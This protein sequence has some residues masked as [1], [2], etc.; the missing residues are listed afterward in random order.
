VG[1]HVEP[2]R[3][4]LVNH[5]AFIDAATGR[6]IR[7]GVGSDGSYV[8]AALSDGTVRG[9]DVSTGKERPI[10]QPNLENIPSIGPGGGSDLQRVVFSRD[11]RSAAFIGE[12]WVQIVDMAG[13]DRRFKAPKALFPIRACE[14]SPDGA[15]LVMVREA[16]AKKFRVGHYSGSSAPTSTVVWLD[17]KTGSVRREIEL[18]ESFVRSL[19]FSPDGQAIAAGTLLTHPARGIIRIFRLQDKNEIQTIESPCPWIEALCYSP[20]GRRIVAGMSDTSIVIWDVRPTD[21]RR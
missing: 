11:G 2:K 12:Q 15:S 21:N 1:F 9:W 19:A 5:L 10:V 13:G 17:S 3:N 20:D 18:P 6:L 14:F 4:V 16:R 8:I 7:R